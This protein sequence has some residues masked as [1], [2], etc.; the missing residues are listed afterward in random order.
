[1]PTS[2]LKL[3]NSVSCVPLIGPT[4]QKKLEKLGI[5]TVEDLLHHYPF[6]YDDYSI[7]SPINQ[8][9]VGEELTIQGKVESIVN[10][11]TKNGKQIIKAV[12][13]DGTGKI[14]TSWFNQAYLLTSFTKDE[15]Y[16]FSGKIAFFGREKTLVSPVFEKAIQGI[17]TGR[18][19]P[20]YPETYGV[21]SKW[22]RS[23]IAA[24]LKI[25]G[26]QLSETLPTNIVRELDLLGENQ[27]IF[28]I[29]FPDN[30]NAIYLAKKRLAFDE[31]LLL[32]LAGISRRQQWQKLQLEAP[33]MVNRE[34]VNAFI[35]RLPYKL[36]V[37]QHKVIKEILA[38]LDNKTPMNRLLQGDVGSGKT[39]V[40][41]IAALVTHDNHQQTL[42]MA[43]T[44]ILA[45]QHYQTFT[46]L[47]LNTNVS[48]SL[49][50]QGHKDI[51]LEAD[52][53]IG[54][55]AL[56][57]QTFTD[58]K[59]GLIV[60]D[61][62]HRF[63]VEQREIIAKKGRAVNLL[64]MTATPIPRTIA[65][66]AFGDLDIS[67]IDELPPGRQVAK[68][69]LV[70]NAKRQDA[71]RW[72]KKRIIDDG[73][74][75][76]IVCPYIDE[77]EN[78]VTVKAA[79]KEFD[80]LRNTVFPDLKL[81]L[82]H[83]RLKSVAKQN[84]LQSFRAGEYHILVATPVVEVGIDIPNATIIIVETA[85]NFGLAELHQLRGRVGRGTK[86]GYCLLFTDS[87]SPEV[88]SRL[89][90]LE[91]LT[92]GNRLAEADLQLRGPGDIFGLRQHGY[93]KLK[94]ADYSDLALIESAKKT[95]N[96][97][98]SQ[99]T[100]TQALQEQLKKVTIQTDILN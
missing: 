69:W 19:V 56:L 83:G 3:T 2:T 62:Q 52:I 46:E 40:A 94:I 29:H 99:K 26:D 60:I 58:R 96:D 18:L 41:A 92:Q 93:P 12:I 10:S 27:A 88:V 68:A 39:V 37:S 63:G 24:A 77:S 43:P 17:H 28:Q 38:G 53:I 91:T 16:R 80:R 47:F 34:S 87:T 76:F 44:E 84:I 25:V 35:S 30:V 82:L 59:I 65:L 20:V 66:A 4:Y 86:P 32:Q 74:Q 36:T 55:H 7:I 100:I 48:I 45:R 72:I 1:M 42:I 98:F 6:R 31:L 51:N 81:A 9:Q 95:A 79:T 22:L 97:L 85:E 50:A 5:F 15:L 11:Y 57:Y 14:T 54:T 67:T 23:R 49:I 8:V 90:L 71:Y 21:S 73:D 64:T 89:K 13:S 70:P 75:V 78:N 33:L 61:E